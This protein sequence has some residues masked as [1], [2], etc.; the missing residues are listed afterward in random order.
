MTL[1]ADFVDASAGHGVDPTALARAVR[2]ARMSRQSHPESPDPEAPPGPAGH[3]ASRL[4]GVLAPGTLLPDEEALP[5]VLSRWAAG[6]TERRP[7]ARRASPT[8]TG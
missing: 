3:A 8:T 6:R 2:F 5:P 1:P 7:A 4:L